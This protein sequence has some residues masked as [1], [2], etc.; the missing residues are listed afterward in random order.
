MQ[1]TAA[2]PQTG[3][4]RVESPEGWYRAG[5]TAVAERRTRTGAGEA[6]NL[7]L[8]IGDGMSLAT[9]SAARI[10]GGQRA[11][12]PG[13][14]HVLPFERFEHLALAKTY[15]T[16]QQT[17]DS[18]GTMTAMFTGVK[19]F[20]G[21]IAVDQRTRRS[22]CA[23]GRG[24]ELV[25]LMDLANQAGL[26]TGIVTTTRITHATPAVAYAKSPERRWE[27]S[28]GLPPTA[29]EQGCR[30]IA[31]QLVEY[32]IG[33]WFDV[34]LGGARSGFLPSET[35]D[36]EYPDRRGRR[37][38]RNDLTEVWQQ[39]FP[40]GYY[41]WNLEQFEALP[42][43]PDGP[44]LGLFERSHMNYRH[45][46]AE[47]GAGEPT[48]TDMT[49]R[50]L[51]ILQQRATAAEDDSGFLLLVESGRID[52]AHHAGNAFRALDETLLL[53]ETVEAVLDRIDRDE[54]L[55]IVTADHGHALTFGGYGSRGNPI[56]G[57]TFGPG[58]NGEAPRL[59]R[60]V[61]GRPFTTLNYINGPGYRD[62][63]RPDLEAGE[64][65]DPDYKQ[66]TVFGVSQS[67]H[68]GEDVPVYATGPGAEALYGSIEQHLIFHVLLQ[69]Q[70]ELRTLA[71]SITGD[72]GL[73]SWARLKD[74]ARGE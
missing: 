55:V 16:N 42:E 40:A 36:P 17:P 41:V 59:S 11:G 49:V 33:G 65:Q 1:P 61:D 35:R 8:F 44:V 62:G 27:E 4:P 43:R 67:T 29:R 3:A 51:D 28:S 70:P 57:R 6:R 64:A 52:H 34:V 68:G 18:A 21:A 53:A 74:G 56:L 15:N 25:S 9:I 32:D 10:L 54:T 20:A 60:D 46:R 24:R 63:E 5:A 73:P 69:A 22:D 14:G 26:S 39:R 2:Q 7:V 38:D 47:D 19:S 50:A 12:G 45:D 13:E 72:D 66:E 23:S 31:R 37:Q 71:E 58:P 48:L 30:D